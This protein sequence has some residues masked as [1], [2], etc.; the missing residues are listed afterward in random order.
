MQIYTKGGKGEGEGEGEERVKC[1][2]DAKTVSYPHVLADIVTTDVPHL[3][4]LSV[5]KFVRSDGDTLARAYNT[6]IIARTADKLIKSGLAFV[7]IPFLSQ[8]RAPPGR[9]YHYRGET[10]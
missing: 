8:K 7:N 1:V 5:R 6:G 3:C 2:S 10:I 4:D 9:N